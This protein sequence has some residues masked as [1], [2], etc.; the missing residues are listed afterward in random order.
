MEYTWRAKE[1]LY[2]IRKRQQETLSK[3]QTK[4]KQTSSPDITT[5]SPN[6]ELDREERHPAPT[7]S[8]FAAVHSGLVGV[9][10]LRLMLNLCRNDDVALRAGDQPSTLAGRF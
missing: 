4:S 8:H 10:L 2:W 7:Y 3:K 5:F 1:S 9:R 6:Q